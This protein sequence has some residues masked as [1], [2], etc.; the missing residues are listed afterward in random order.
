MGTQIQN[1]NTHPS[2]KDFF[3]RDIV[4]Q[5]FEQILGKNASGF[6]A[7]ILQIAMSN[8]MLKNADPASI[9]QSAAVA[10]TLSLPLNN[11]LGFAYIVPF[12]SKQKD[13][14]YKILAQ[15]QIGAKGFKQLALRTGQF[16]RINDT[17]VREGEIKSQDRLSG[18]IQFEWINDEKER[19]SKPIVGYASYFKLN[20]GFEKS[21]YMTVE[22][23]Q[24][25]GKKFSQTFKKGFG[26]WKDEFDSMARKTVTKLNLSKNAP[27]S[28]ELQ[29]A[30][31]TDQSIVKDAETNQV[32]YP[33]NENIIEDA[34]VVS[35]GKEDERII[36]F[37]NNSK[38]LK[39]LDEALD[40]LNSES[41][42]AAYEAKKE[43]LKNVK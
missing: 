40:F 5:K 41:A 15:F 38:D 29:T 34:E 8:D 24:Q 39:Q 21:Y 43:D 31:T 7:S 13:G 3:S 2:L 28:I 16:V 10:A 19:M 27:L 37:I 23:L 36:E 33:D 14:S 4:K 1:T 42:K 22:E 17:D 6:I 35:E 30:I 26:L 9:F 32:E 11:S 25:H 20:N 18:D 12:N